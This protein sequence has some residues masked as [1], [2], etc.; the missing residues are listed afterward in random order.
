MPDTPSPLV[1]VGTD[2][3]GRTAYLHPTAAVAWLLAVEL[4]KRV[5]GVDLSSRILQALGSA[6][7]S[8]G[9]HERPACAVDIRVWGWSRAKILA[10]VLLLRNAGFEATWYRDWPGNEHIHA[11]ADIGI[12]TPARYQITAVRKGQNGL[13]NR[14]PDDGPRPEAWRTAAQ[15][16]E[17]SRS[18]LQALSTKPTPPAPTGGLTMSEYQAIK[19]QLDAI[20]ARISALGESVGGRAQIE[21]I[22]EAAARQTQRYPVS[23]G[24]KLIPAIQEI[25][26]AKSAAQQAVA[27]LGALTRLTETAASQRMT[28]DQLLAIAKTGAE[29]ALTDAVVKVEIVTGQ[30]A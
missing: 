20:D 6:S 13:T 11:A 1:S 26:D 7:A 23:R 8:A 3:K 28:P 10:V 4:A 30:E 15:G 5:L 14:G 29:Q 27:M 22:G 9:V 21:R 25:A 16:A 2:T 12:W 24:G 18:K 19:T 17:W